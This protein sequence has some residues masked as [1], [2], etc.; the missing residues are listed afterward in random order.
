MPNNPVCRPQPW[1]CRSRSVGRE[2]KNRQI[3]VSGVYAKKPCARP[4]ALTLRFRP[5]C[6]DR[7]TY[8]SLLWSTFIALRA[9][10]V[11]DSGLLV[12]TPKP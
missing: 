9:V 12:L 3:Q 10:R 2:G 7:S 6:E 5:G 8:V 11:W 4:L 1:L